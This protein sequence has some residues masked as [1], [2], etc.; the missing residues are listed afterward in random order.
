VNASLLILSYALNG[1][2]SDY[3]MV[4]LK[5]ARLFFVLGE[6]LMFVT[7][8]LG[9]RGNSKSFMLMLGVYLISLPGTFITILPF[10]K[11][12]GSQ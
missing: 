10:Y 3:M 6:V 1:F 9:H 12:I 11:F 7:E 5:L 8:F 2:I 4:D